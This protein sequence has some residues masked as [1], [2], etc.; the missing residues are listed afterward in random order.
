MRTQGVSKSRTHQRGA[1]LVE[2]TL[3]LTLVALPLVAGITW[4][5]VE[6]VQSYNQQNAR[7]LNARP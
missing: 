5:A 3:L 2:Y 6:L 1:V 7:I 4:G